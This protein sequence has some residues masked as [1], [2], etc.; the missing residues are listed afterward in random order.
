MEICNG[1]NTV[2]Y[3]VMKNLSGIITKNLINSNNKVLKLT[4]AFSLLIDQ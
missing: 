4:T 2:G 1:N 3:K